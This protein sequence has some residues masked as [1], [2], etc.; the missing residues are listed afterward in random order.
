MRNLLDKLDPHAEAALRH[1]IGGAVRTQ[2]L[3]VAATLAIADKLA[4][5][6]RSASELAG[7]ARADA[8]TLRRVLRYLVSSGVFIEREDGRFALN[9]AAEYL[10]S[11]HPRSLRPSAIRAGE[12][13]WNVAGRLLD[14]VR[15][16]STPHEALHESSFFETMNQQSFAARMAFSAADLGPAIAADECFASARS[17]VDVGGGQGAHLASI[18]HAHPRLRGILFDTAAMLA[19]AERT[20][21]DVRERCE[22]VAGDFF[23]SVPDGDVYLL[24]WILHDWNDAKAAQILRACRR[25]GATLLIAEV[26][27]PDQAQQIVESETIADPFTL[28]MQ[29]LL[30]TGGRERTL[31]EYRTLLEETGFALTSVRTPPSTRGASILTARAK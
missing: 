4:L 19:G 16:G 29:M 15:R 6:P 24:S 28:D 20:L 2:A 14:A 12:N 21:Q 10:Q 23:Q 26:L 3:Y 9:A 30:L 27:L 25:E 17:V 31:E 8:A 5:G 1:M 13:L 18:L 7:E 22:L 11:G